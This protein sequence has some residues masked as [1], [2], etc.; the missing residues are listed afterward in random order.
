MRRI[1]FDRSIVAMVAAL[2]LTVS[3]TSAPTTKTPRSVAAPATTPGLASP[4]GSP[5][6]PVTPS[7]VGW[8][9]YRSRFGGFSF[10]YPPGWHLTPFSGGCGAYETGA[11]VANVPGAV[12][13]SPHPSDPCA[14]PQ[15]AGLPAS[16]VAINV[17]ILEGGPPIIVP[18]YPADTKLP[19]RLAAVVR[20]GGHEGVTF[21]HIARYSVDATVGSKL[22]AADYADAEA[23]VASVRP[24]APARPAPHF[25]RCAGGWD[26]EPL[27]STT[28]VSAEPRSVAAISPT[29]VWAVGT[30]SRVVP[31]ADTP[32]TSSPQLVSAP[33][34]AHW[35]GSAWT[36]VRVPDPNLRRTSFGIVGSGSFRDVAAVASDDVWAVGGGQGGIIEHWDG[37]AWSVVPT[38]SVG[39]VDDTLD[40]VAATGPDD[41]WAVGTGGRV[42]VVERWDGSRWTRSELPDLGSAWSV[43]EDVA[44]SSPADAWVVGYGA[45]GA[46]ALHWNGTAWTAVPTPDI[47]SPRLAGVVDLGPD[48]AWAVGTTYR[49]PPG[50]GPRHALVEHWDGRTWTAVPVAGLA[51]GSALSAVSATGPDDLWAVG[52]STETTGEEHPTMLHFDGTR[53]S[54]V[55]PPA[56]PF[57][58]EGYLGLASDGSRTWL[59]TIEGAEESFQP[60]RPLLVRS[61]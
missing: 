52:D 45:N 14:V 6:V 9:V 60:D 39:L 55:R 16:G 51:Q 12:Q 36:V 50:G 24:W 21:H 28:I 7:T 13:G 23:V 27:A 58:G 61:C 53:W 41:A 47:R 37:A 26:R 25:G 15:M 10:R 31:P 40:A 5:G 54:T 17:D 48:D 11:V 49:S 33:L 35:D 22:S 8:P 2:A 43:G 29:D 18:T 34:A 44:A 32:A 59:A 3:C 46:V 57:G 4:T 30:S 1:G 56:A 42:P 20:H 38:P 19:I